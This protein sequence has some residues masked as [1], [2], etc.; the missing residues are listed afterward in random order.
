VT[1][2]GLARAR[3]HLPAHRERLDLFNARGT[4]LLA[5][6]LVDTTGRAL[7][8]FTSRA[9]AEEF[10]REDPFVVHGVVAAWTVV[11]WNEVLL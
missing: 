4:L 5:G 9:A 7:G 11:E 8:V 1:P 2:E 6:P 3:D 10:I